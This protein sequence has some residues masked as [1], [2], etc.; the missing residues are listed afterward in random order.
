MSVSRNMRARVVVRLPSRSEATRRGCDDA[1]CET[2]ALW[3]PER[4]R[5]WAWI[6]GQGLHGTRHEG[7]GRLRS[8]RSYKAG[9]GVA[10]RPD[11]MHADVVLQ[12]R[13]L[14]P[15]Q[16]ARR[17]IPRRLADDSITSKPCAAASS[18]PAGTNVF[19]DF[20]DSSTPTNCEVDVCIIGAGAAGIAIA[21]AFLTHRVRV[22]VVESGGMDGEL[23]SQS[24]CEGESIGTPNF[25][26]FHS[27][28][29]AYG[30]SCNLWGGGCVR[31]SALDM[32]ARDWVPHS[33]WPISPADLTPW[34]RRAAKLCGLAEHAIDER[35]ALAAPMRRLATFEPDTL[36]NS[37][38]ARSPILFGRAF[39]GEFARASDV[40]VLLHAN[41]LELAVAEDGRSVRCARIGSLSGRRG[42]IRARHFVLASGGIEN[43]RLL[44]L[45]DATIAGG[46]GNR[47]G[48]VGRYFM[49]HPCGKIGSL[50]SPEL[51]RFVRP[52]DRCADGGRAPLFP[53]IGLSDGAQC[54]HRT[55]NARV[56]SFAVEEPIPR[57]LRALRGLR[58]VLH[59]PPLDEA[60]RL[61]AQLC[62]AMR[63]H[64][65]V[66][67]IPVPTSSV[68]ALVLQL[69]IGL[70]DVARAFGRKLDGKPAVRTRHVDLWGYFEQAPNWQSRVG[71]SHERDA[72]DLRKC[73][74]EW[75]LTELDHHTFRV[76][77]D[78]FGT[79]LARACK[80]H[81]EPLPWLTD[82]SAEPPVHGTAHHLG[83]TRMADDPRQGVVDRNSRVHGMD[84]LHIAGSSVF[85]TGGG[86]AFPTLTIVALSLRLAEHLQSSCAL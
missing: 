75:R 49:D 57:G 71:L 43:A 77:A 17:Q 22:C 39:H 68:G 81:F 35:D 73:R 38:C 72:L 14:A 74:I 80:G 48:L 86:W 47:Y 8:C 26:A 3:R 83:T 27:R 58:Q 85:P 5:S 12:A 62:D 45:S 31:L 7:A 52:Y 33:G 15:H 23:R 41:V 30:G 46:L 21:S 11:Q 70:G 16:R 24:L 44:L 54:E 84:N 2:R 9:E 29:R 76:S 42:E 40:T 18:S 53:E 25:D 59:G 37:I 69:G 63:H 6:P 50:H 36:A 19:M 56:H 55:L 64:A 4:H 66:P 82:E 13:M 78:L 61:E 65:P 51:E 1:A 20:L 28:M 60:S 79:E 32:S 10:I 34:Y 67:L